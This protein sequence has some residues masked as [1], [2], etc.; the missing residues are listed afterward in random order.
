MPTVR[1]EIVLPVPRERAWELLCE[2][3]EWLADEAALDPEPG[4]EVRAAWADG[5]VR[6]GV[7]QEVDPGERIR[8]RWWDEDAAGSDVEW[9]LEDVVAGTRVVVVERALVP[10]AWGPPL[11]MLARASAGALALA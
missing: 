2:P 7:V 10:V 3:A 9:R 4:G 5:E 11:E 1:R 6:E 8:F